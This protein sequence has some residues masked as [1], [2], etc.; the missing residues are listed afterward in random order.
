[1]TVKVVE[2]E[3]GVVAGGGGEFVAPGLAEPDAADEPPWLQPAEKMS[4]ASHGNA[5]ALL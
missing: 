5:V 2:V 1:M 4:A 3:G